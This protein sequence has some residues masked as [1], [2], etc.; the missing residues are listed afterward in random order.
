M[1]ANSVKNYFEDSH[2]SGCTDALA[3]A[4]PNPA[5]ALKRQKAQKKTGH[6]RFRKHPVTVVTCLVF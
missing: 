1:G 5:L 6:P 3:Q 4:V 2:R